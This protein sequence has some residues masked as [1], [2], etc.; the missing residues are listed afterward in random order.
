MALVVQIK[1]YP[2]SKGSTSKSVI[3]QED[4]IDMVAGHVTKLYNELKTAEETTVTFYRS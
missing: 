3:I 2:Y 1:K 4:N